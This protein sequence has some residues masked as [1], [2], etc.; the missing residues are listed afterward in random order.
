MSELITLERGS[1]LW[2]EAKQELV[3]QPKSDSV[4]RLRQE[5]E[6]LIRENL[7][8]VGRIVH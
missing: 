8:R 5:H 3:E 7:P 6:R 1:W 2:D 4:E